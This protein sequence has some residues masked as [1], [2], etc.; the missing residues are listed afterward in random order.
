MC[1]PIDHDGTKRH[2]GSAVQ[3]SM[4]FKFCSI[5][6]VY[7]LSPKLQTLAKDTC[8]NN[9][10]I[11]TQW[12]QNLDATRGQPYQPNWALYLKRE[13]KNSYVREKKFS[14]RKTFF[15][16]SFVL[17]DMETGILRPPPMDRN[18]TGRWIF[19]QLMILGRY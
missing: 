1:D 6:L 14:P 18:W 4:R 13:K 8:A 10:P 19:Q 12:V 16:F 7:V 15:S 9:Q 3:I 11:P 2:S 17:G 5:E